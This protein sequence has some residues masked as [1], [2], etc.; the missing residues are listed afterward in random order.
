[1]VTS[2]KKNLKQIWKSSTGLHKIQCLSS[3][4]VKEKTKFLPLFPR[5]KSNK[6][7]QAKPKYKFS[8]LPKWEVLLE[9]K[10]SPTSLDIVKHYKWL[11]ETEI[12][13]PLQRKTWCL[14]ENQVLWNI[15]CRCQYDRN[16]KTTFSF[17]KSEFISCE[18]AEFA[19][20]HFLICSWEH[21]Q[22]SWLAL[23]CSSPDNFNTKKRP[24]CCL[25]IGMRAGMGSHTYGQWNCWNYL[26]M[27]FKSGLIYIPW[28]R[29]YVLY[30]AIP[31]I[32][33]S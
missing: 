2:Y 10:Y 33:N 18:I 16:W 12:I 22:A 13:L 21:A 27:V 25:S 17:T 5:Q 28:I 6:E 7:N 1:M 29:R 32:L 30:Y 8:Y 23:R 31:G 19:W 24:T 15:Y 3:I 20:N 4:F 26:Q 11:E 9:N 14:H